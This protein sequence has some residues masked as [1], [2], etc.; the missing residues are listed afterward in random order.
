MKLYLD[1]SVWNFRLNIHVPDKQ[2]ITQEFFGALQGVHEPFVSILVLE[3]LGRTPEEVRRSALFSHLEQVSPGFLNWVPEVG[4]IADRV[5]EMGGLTERSRADAVHVGYAVVHGM[6][7]LVSWNMHDLVKLK[8][9][10]IVA[11]VCRLLGYKELEI[12]T[13]EEV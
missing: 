7:A 9:K 5:I 6:D 2:R 4:A 1:T 11:G 13:P 8:T 10:R 3:E 12:V